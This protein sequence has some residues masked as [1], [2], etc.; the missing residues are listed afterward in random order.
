[1][2]KNINIVLGDWDTCKADAAAIRYAVFVLEQQVPIELEMDEHDVVCVHA[3]AYNE[4]GLPL[5][6]GR[7]L[8]DGHIGRMAVGAEYRSLG[9]GSMLLRALIDEARVRQYLEVVL[10]AQLHAQDFYARHGF[11][12]EGPVYM[13]AGIEH[14]TMR[15]AL[16]A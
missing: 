9:V 10:S 15:H 1:M 16:T 7:L 3:V 11:V 5:G 13:D 8:P 12:A 4:E 14:V 6:T 2:N